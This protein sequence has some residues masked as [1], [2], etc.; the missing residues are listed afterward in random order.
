MERQSMSESR[1][2]RWLVLALLTGAFAILVL[3]S[4]WWE[5]VLRF[6]FPA[7]SEVLHPRGL[8]VLV[9]EHLLLVAVSSSITILVGLP[10]GIWVTRLL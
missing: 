5:F 9:G 4:D 10:L 3:Q 6:F 7:E 2:R 1:A 8:A